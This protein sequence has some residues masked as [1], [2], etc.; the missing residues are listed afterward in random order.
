MPLGHPVEAVADLGVTGDGA[1]FR[2]D[3]PAHQA[4][5]R[6]GL[7]LGVGVER[8][9]DLTTCGIDAVIDGGRLAG[10]ALGDQLDSF[11]AA[12]RLG[13]DCRGFV[14]GAVVDDNDFQ[15]DADAL[16]DAAHAAFDDAGFVIGRDN[17]TDEGRLKEGFRTLFRRIHMPAV[18]RVDSQARQNQGAS[19]AQHD[20]DDKQPFQPFRQSGQGH[21]DADVEADL[22]Q[23]GAGQ[24]RHDLFRRQP[25]QVADRDELIA[26]RLQGANNGR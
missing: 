18:F 10:I 9:D 13:D 12:K 25:H 23:F 4:R 8:D 2:T 16:Q 6:L 26:L 22:K 1:D 24:G 19:D 7:E 21:E 11:V 5:D 20:G 15:V 17:D 14:L 3:E